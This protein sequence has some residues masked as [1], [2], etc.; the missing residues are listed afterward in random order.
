VTVGTTA[1]VEDT[2]FANQTRADQAVDKDELTP[3]QN[4][5]EAGRDV[6]GLGETHTIAVPVMTGGKIFF[7]CRAGTN[8]SPISHNEHSIMVPIKAPYASGQAPLTSV[9]S[10]AVVDGHFPLAYILSNRVKAGEMV[11][12]DAPTTVI[13]PVP[14]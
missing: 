13:I 7:S 10:A 5:F 11:A 8:E 2:G 12:N 14:R 3:T 9:P 1:P 6:Y 4:R